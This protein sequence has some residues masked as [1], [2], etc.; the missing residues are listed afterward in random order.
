MVC[1]NLEN[2][3]LEILDDGKAMHVRHLE[4]TTLELIAFNRH[5]SNAKIGKL[6]TCR[7]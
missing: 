6:K 4:F 3:W 2:E 5:G 1:D 7:P